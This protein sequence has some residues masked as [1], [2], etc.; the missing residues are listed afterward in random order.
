MTKEIVTPPLLKTRSKDPLESSWR[1]HMS[2]GQWVP[3]VSVNT[4]MLCR[5]DFG[6]WIRRHHCRRCGAVICDGCSGSRTKFI[7]KEIN[8]NQAAEED[9]RVCDACIQV[10]DEKLALGV[11]RRFGKGVATALA[12]NV[13]DS[14]Q[15]NNHEMKVSLEPEKGGNRTVMT[16]GRYRA[17]IKDSEGN[18]YICDTDL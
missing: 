2:D 13:S 18:R 3:D 9:C 7:N 14:R 17:E 12:T 5:T 10:I 15:T 4:C 16:M 11:S 6:F 1:K 8:V